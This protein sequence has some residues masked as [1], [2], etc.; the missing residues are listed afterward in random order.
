MDAKHL[1]NVIFF[2]KALVLPICKHN[3]LQASWICTRIYLHEQLWL[4]GIVILPNTHLD[5]NAMKDVEGM[6]RMMLPPRI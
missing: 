5:L 2:H 3:P 6:Q 1:V 4:Q